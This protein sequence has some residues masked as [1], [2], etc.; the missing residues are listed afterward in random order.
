MTAYSTSEIVKHNIRLSNWPECDWAFD[1]HFNV[2]FVRE[3]TPLY[4]Y[5]ALKLS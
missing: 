2:V 1:Q 3:N 5:L 4:T